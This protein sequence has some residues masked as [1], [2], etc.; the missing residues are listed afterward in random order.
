MDNVRAAKSAVPSSIKHTMAYKK[1]KE[2]D[3]RAIDIAPALAQ[4]K[5]RDNFDVSNVALVGFRFCK[6]GV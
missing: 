3:D 6:H 1:G 2:R 4:L 5:I